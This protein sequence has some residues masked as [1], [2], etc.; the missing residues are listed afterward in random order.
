MGAAWH[1][2]GGDKPPFAQQ[3]QRSVSP[4]LSRLRCWGGA[5][6]RTPLRQA[7]CRCNSVTQPLSPKTLPWHLVGCSTSV[8]GRRQKPSLHPHMYLEVMLRVQPHHPSWVQGHQEATARAR[9]SPR[10]SHVP[11]L[12]PKGSPKGSCSPPAPPSQVSLGFSSCSQD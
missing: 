3:H 8:A 1:P 6:P 5:F 4:L 9:C 10:S 2:S 12:S 7:W 11:P